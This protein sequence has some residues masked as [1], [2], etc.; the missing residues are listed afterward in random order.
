VAG[1][2]LG[3]TELL[4]PTAMIN[5]LGQPSIPQSVLATHDVTSHWYGKTAKPGRKMGHIN[6][7]ADNLH[8]LGERLAALAEIL[9]EEDYPGVANTSTQLIL[10]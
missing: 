6:V 8:Q 7:S 1:L 3:S 4:R 5:V 2:P 10:N 9:P